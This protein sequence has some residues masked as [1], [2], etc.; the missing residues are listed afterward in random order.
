VDE[1]WALIDSGRAAE[2]P[3][4]LEA[5]S[6]Q[7]HGE[8]SHLL[9][10]LCARGA[11]TA[12]DWPR[13]LTLLRRAADQGWGRAQTELRLIGP[14]I[15]PGH[16]FAAPEAVK[17]C[18]QPRVRRIDGFVTS[19]ICDWLIARARDQLK[20]AATLERDQ[21]DQRTRTISDHR[22]NS[23]AV[24][25]ILEGGVVM[26]V[27]AERIARALKVPTEVF[28]APQVFHY[29]TGQQYQLH[30]DYIEGAEAQRIATF[31]IYLNADFEAGETWFSI[32]D[33]KVKPGK[34]GAVYFANV[35]LEGRPDPLSLH[36][37]TAPTRGE[38]WLLSQ[39]IRDRPYA[40]D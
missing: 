31:L 25:S 34:G 9:A 16:L 28:E 38:K 36:A 13:A 33:L 17:L 30:I 1:F 10:I 39:W 20:P 29:A 15:D 40:N 22:T 19:E 4:A 7:G 32:P 35:D 27:I 8:A 23:A 12:K 18:E 37:G 5:A 2:A 6:Q 3:A 26:A 14:A 11:M 24:I 21:T